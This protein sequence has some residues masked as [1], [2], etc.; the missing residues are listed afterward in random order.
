MPRFYINFQ[1]NDHIAQDDEGIDVP[2]LEAAQK[3][4]LISAREIVADNVKANS[5]KPL[6]AVI[7]TD[8]NGQNLMTISAKDVLPESFK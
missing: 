5:K 4:A 3:A 6:R 7:I 8:E 2:D 1:N